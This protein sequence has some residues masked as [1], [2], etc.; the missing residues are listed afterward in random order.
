[1]DQDVQTTD[2]VN[3]NT[4]SEQG[5]RIGPIETV[6]IALGGDF[7]SGQEIKVGRTRDQIIISSIGYLTH[8]TAS[9]I[10]SASGV[11]FSRFRPNN[12]KG[13]VFHSGTVVGNLEIFSGGEVQI[14]YVDTSDGSSIDQ[15]NT[16][17]SFTISYVLG[18]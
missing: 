11:I 3:F 15:S 10:I 8:S 12:D 14:E 9:S 2:D 17:K 4:V 7:D 5:T 13:N 18:S 6:T 16:T 1:M